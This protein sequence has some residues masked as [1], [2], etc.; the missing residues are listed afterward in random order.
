MVFSQE[1]GLSLQNNFFRRLHHA[2]GSTGT[3]KGSNRYHR[4][5]AL[6]RGRFDRLWA[7]D[8]CLLGVFDRAHRRPLTHSV[9]PTRPNE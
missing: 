7:F 8:N 1:M 9:T 3:E 4:A 5:K 2:T 6:A